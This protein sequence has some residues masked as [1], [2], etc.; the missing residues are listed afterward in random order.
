MRSALLVRSF[1]CVVLPA[2]LQSAEYARHVFSSAPN[3]TPEAVGSAVA[4]LVERQSVLYEPQRESVF[5]SGCP[6]TRTN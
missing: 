6:P 3:A 1:Q 5:E 2:M 4:A